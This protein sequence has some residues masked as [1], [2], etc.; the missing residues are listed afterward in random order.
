MRRNYSS[1]KRDSD[2]PEIRDTLDKN[3]RV[4]SSSGNGASDKR[5]NLDKSNK[6]QL[7]K[8]AHLDT[9]PHAEVDRV[10]VRGRRKPCGARPKEEGRHAVS[11]IRRAEDQRRR[12]GMQLARSEELKTAWEPPGKVGF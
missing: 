11:K 8:K 6:K 10:E 7:N 4:E 12:G 3:M 1:M 9:S 5:G 2:N